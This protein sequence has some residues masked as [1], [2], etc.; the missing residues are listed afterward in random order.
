MKKIMLSEFE[1]VSTVTKILDRI[2]AENTES[3]SRMDY[4]TRPKGYGYEKFYLNQ[5]DGSYDMSLQALIHYI[6]AEENIYYQILN[7]D[8]YAKCMKVITDEPEAIYYPEGDSDEDIETQDLLD[9]IYYRSIAYTGKKLIAMGL[10]VS[11]DF[12]DYLNGTDY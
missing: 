9:T 8:Q 10:N 3:L 1:V 11:H 7:E 12:I 5:V 4:M 2:I 6:M